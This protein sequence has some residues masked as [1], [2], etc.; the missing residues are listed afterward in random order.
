MNGD[1]NKIKGATFQITDSSLKD[2][3]L[4]TTKTFET[5]MQYFT[6]LYWGE[7]IYLSMRENYK[8][9]HK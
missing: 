9:Y 2:P 6:A 8:Q 1:P 4:P 3:S 7:A 5:K